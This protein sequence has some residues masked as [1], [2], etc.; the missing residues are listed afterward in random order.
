MNEAFI[1]MLSN[2]LCIYVEKA[3]DVV[4]CE[5]LGVDMATILENIDKLF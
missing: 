1:F 3:F 5:N 2:N 4:Y